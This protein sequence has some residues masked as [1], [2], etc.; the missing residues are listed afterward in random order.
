MKAKDYQK[1]VQQNTPKVPLVR[2]MAWAFLVGGSF[3]TLG[4][5][6]FNAAQI[7]ETT[8]DEAAAVTLATMILVG[9]ILTGFGVY[10]EIA[11]KAGAG[12]AVPITG[13]ANTI[14]AAAVEFRREGLLLGMGAGMFTIAG[15]VIVY[16]VL[17]GFFVSVLKA[18]FLG[19]F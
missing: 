11:E 12:A 6:F 17:A 19:L 16:G 3:C 14:A 10:D 8:E 1:L 7:L 13:F 2:N 9:T 5:V 18:L 4:Q 15:P